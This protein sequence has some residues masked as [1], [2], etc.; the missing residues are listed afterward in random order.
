M[1][2]TKFI[3]HLAIQAYNP[4]APKSPS[5]KRDLLAEHFSRGQGPDPRS[6]KQFREQQDA[7]K[8]AVSLPREL[9]HDEQIQEDA[10]ALEGQY[11]RST[12]KKPNYVVRRVAAAGAAGGLLVGG[13][14]FVADALHNQ[15]TVNANIVHVGKGMKAQIDAENI[16]PIRNAVIRSMSEQNASEA[17]I[18]SV[19]ADLPMP[20][21]T[22]TSTA[23]PQ[24][25]RSQ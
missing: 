5:E 8:R 22:S 12:G 21:T 1:A 14:A 18:G 4:D 7:L 15:A 23:P 16:N 19:L 13:G 17:E 25:P 2:E 9:S 11:P 6:T 3:N 24:N 20:T 10:D